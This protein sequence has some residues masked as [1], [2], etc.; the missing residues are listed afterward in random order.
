ML[1]LAQV[2]L[3]TR[4]LQEVLLNLS[5]HPARLKAFEPPNEQRRDDSERGARDECV[6]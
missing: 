6:S 3:K 2:P 5:D 1:L 4:V